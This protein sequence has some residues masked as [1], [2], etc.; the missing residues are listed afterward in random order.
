MMKIF[1]KI[2][3]IREDQ[4]TFI[5]HKTLII[6]GKNDRKT[7]AKIFFTQIF[8]IFPFVLKGFKKPSFIL[9]F[10]L[11]SQSYKMVHL[12]TYN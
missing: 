10:Q 11:P 1:P 12:L 6:T 3:S 4:S 5:L 2:C 7:Y 8:S 9:Y